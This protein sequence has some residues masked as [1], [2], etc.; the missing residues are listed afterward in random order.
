M[1]WILAIFAE[2]GRPAFVDELSSVY[3]EAASHV[4]KRYAALAILGSGGTVSISR[5]EWARSP[6]LVR[7]ALLGASDLRGRR[8][9][10]LRGVLE[11]LIAVGS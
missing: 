10:K 9:L 2:K 5:G 1:T 3:E 11:E 6:A 4:V 8:S 7:S